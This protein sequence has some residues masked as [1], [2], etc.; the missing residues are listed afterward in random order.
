MNCHTFL[1]SKTSAIFETNIKAISIVVYTDTKW[2]PNHG[3]DTPDAK[4]LPIIRL[5]SLLSDNISYQNDEMDIEI[6]TNTK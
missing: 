3:T 5:L 2:H 6:L 1:L 4:W